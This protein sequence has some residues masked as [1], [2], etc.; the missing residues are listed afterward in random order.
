MN[1]VQ[2]IF[3]VAALVLL[4]L[5]A[6]GVPSSRVSLGWAGLACWLTGAVFVPYLA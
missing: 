3:Y 4:V 2:L 1:P 6:L 5:A